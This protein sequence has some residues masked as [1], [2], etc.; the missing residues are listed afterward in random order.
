[1]ATLTMEQCH[2]LILEAYCQVGGVSFAKALIE[3][4]PNEPPG[5]NNLPWC[6]CGRCRAM[7]TPQENVCC[8]NCPCISNTD[9]F[10]TTEMSYLL[11]LSIE[12]MYTVMRADMNQV[13][14]YHQW[15]MWRCGYL[16]RA[17]RKVI[18]GCV[19]W[20]VR[21]KYPAPD[22]NDLKSIDRNCYYQIKLLT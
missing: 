5:D 1:M 21:R 12:L 2:K 17:N 11:Q 7:P 4:G 22:G 16:G 19:V 18:P 20:A 15:T 6:I 13:I 10:E 8:K 14:T 3:G 9:M